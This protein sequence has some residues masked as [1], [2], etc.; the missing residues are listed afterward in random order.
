[1]QENAKAAVELMRV[2]E[3]ASELDQHQATIY[4]KVHAGQIPA[5]RLGEG[6]AAIRIRRGELELWLR[7]NRA[8]PV[9][10][11]GLRQ[12]QLRAGAASPERRETSVS[13]QSTSQAHAGL[14]R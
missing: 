13:R 2:K 4:R 14:E 12:E 1:M 9:S 10:D 5:V 11:D 3:V 8:S 7:E 6:R